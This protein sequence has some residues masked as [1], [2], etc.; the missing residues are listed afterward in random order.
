MTPTQKKMINKGM[1]METINIF[2]H[3]E[4]CDTY[5]YFTLLKSILNK[6]YNLHYL[7]N[8]NVKTTRTDYEF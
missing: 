8:D 1:E 7:C 2:S 3:F 6:F 5:M 4:K